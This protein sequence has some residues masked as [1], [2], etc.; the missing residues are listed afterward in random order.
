MAT[1]TYTPLTT[2]T[3][4]ATASSVTITVPS[5]YTDIRLVTS[6]RSS[7]GNAAIITFNGDTGSHYSRVRV[8][9]TGSAASSY[10]Y[11]NQVRLISDAVSTSTSTFGVFTLDLM[12]YANTTTYKTCLGRDNSD[13]YTAAWVGLWRGSTGSAV[14]EP[15]TSITLAPDSGVWSIGSTFSLYGI[16]A[17]NVGAKALGGV[18]TSDSTYWYHTFANSG[19][20]TPTQS[21]SADIFVIA[22]GGAGS[23]TAAGG[24]G[25][26]GLVYN[27]S[28]SLAN[29]T[30]YTCTVGAGGAYVASTRTN[31]SNSSVTGG[32]LSLTAAVGGGGGGYRAGSAP[33]RN[34]ADG[35]SGGGGAYQSGTGGNP[36]SGQGYAGGIAGSLTVAGGGGGGFSVAG[37]NVSEVS[38]TQGYG[39]AGG[40]GT[41][42]YSSWGAAT[43]TGQLV[44]S[45]YYYA[46]GGGGGNSGATNV[47][48]A[49]AV[50]GYG[51]GGAGGQTVSNSTTPAPTTGGVSGSAGLANTGGGGGGGGQNMGSGAD[52]IGASGGSGIVIVRYAK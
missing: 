50:G 42:T 32:A 37:G 11:S 23:G 39:G 49:A 3:L 28:Q 10:A 51:G 34:G 12:N 6:L 27:A 25:A 22:G 33:N 30:N 14:N 7:S 16:T 17:S 35:G 5:G 36:T 44:S 21:L 29:G 38:A 41:S 8:L 13:L 24:G 40:N 46:G 48:A 43:N 2:N 47:G 1:S 4:S 9:G 19:T 26:G 52:G 31:G 18:V 15:I 20:F 45:T